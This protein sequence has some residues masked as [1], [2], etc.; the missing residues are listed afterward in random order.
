MKHKAIVITTAVAALAVVALAGTQAVAL[1]RVVK[2][3]D[4]AT[5]AMKINL[6]YMGTPVDVTFNTVHTVTKV[7]DDG[8]YVASEE[9]KDTVVMV[10]GQEIA[11]EDEASTI[12]YAKDGSII[13]IEAN[14]STGDGYRLANLSTTLWPTAP[15]DVKSKWERSI[16]GDS[17]KG[18]FDVVHS[19]EVLARERLLGFETFKIAYNAK[20]TG[21]GTA[22]TAGTIWLDVKTGLPVKI[23]G[24]MKSV[25]IQGIPMDATFVL[26]LKKP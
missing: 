25:P 23:E 17:A 7:N 3:G 13:K 2:A 24:E 22:S 10:D 14:V 11:G 5:Y 4:K 21:S 6:D 12:T 1:K 15:V 9:Q 19:Y 8:S 20:E 18:T 26:T 16:K